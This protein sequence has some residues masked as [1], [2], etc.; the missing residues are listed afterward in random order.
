MLPP[1]MAGPQVPE[2]VLRELPAK[3]KNASVFEIRSTA[4]GR[5]LPDAQ[6]HQ[7]WRNGIQ[8]GT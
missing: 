6:K 4:K 2:S 5:V 1:K 7:P 3:A 8:A